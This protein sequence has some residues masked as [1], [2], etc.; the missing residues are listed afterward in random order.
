MP[1]EGLPWLPKEQQ[2]TDDEVVRLVRVAVERLGVTEVRV[3]GGGAA[4]PP[5]PGGLP[6]G[7]PPAGAPRTGPGLVGI[8]AAAAGLEPRP[9]LSVTTNGI[10]LERLAGPLRDA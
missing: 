1:A 7:G 3:T 2:L 10:G 9:R 6:G 4:V 8:V 5:R